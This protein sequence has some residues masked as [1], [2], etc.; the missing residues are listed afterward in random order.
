MSQV[1]FTSDTLIKLWK[2]TGISYSKHY[3]VRILA[4]ME[5]LTYY[6]AATG[7]IHKEL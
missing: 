4:A 1:Y 6:K 5:Y 2:A 7:P 3:Y